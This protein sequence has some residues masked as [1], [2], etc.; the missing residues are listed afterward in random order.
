MEKIFAAMMQ[1][2]MQGKTAEGRK[3]FEAC[4]EKMASMAPCCGGKEISPEAMK[5]MPEEMKNMMA[6]MKAFCCGTAD[7]ANPMSCCGQAPK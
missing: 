7:G 2:C 6:K 5:A 3:D 4:M 1:G